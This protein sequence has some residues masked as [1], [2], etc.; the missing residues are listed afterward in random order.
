MKIMKFVI[1]FI[2][3]VFSSPVKFEWKGNLCRRRLHNVWTSCWLVTKISIPPSGSCVWILQVWN[4]EKS[5]MNFG[6]YR[7]TPNLEYSTFNK[8]CKN[9][10][11]NFKFLNKLFTVFWIQFVLNKMDLMW[12]RRLKKPIILLLIL[13]VL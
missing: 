8:I 5:K 10:F 12:K 2:Y 7:V 3:F 9:C 6:V 11:F 4:K 13:F 1:V